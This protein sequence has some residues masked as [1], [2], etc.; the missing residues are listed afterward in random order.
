MS[1]VSDYDEHH[2]DEEKEQVV[3]F[4]AKLKFFII[5]S[6]GRS[7]LGERLISGTDVAARFLLGWMAE[8]RIL[9]Q[10]V[11]KYTILEILITAEP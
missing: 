7:T 6:V 2:Y 10:C 8:R 5:T 1:T 4:V 9:L 11:W 3:S